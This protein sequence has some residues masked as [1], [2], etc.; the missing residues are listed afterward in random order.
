MPSCKRDA[1]LS[2]LGNTANLM[3]RED[4]EDVA[5]VGIDQAVTA[6]VA[7]GHLFSLLEAVA[8]AADSHRDCCR[9]RPGS[10]RRQ[11]AAPSG[12]PLHRV[13]AREGGGH[14]RVFF[15]CSMN[16][17]ADGVLQ[18]FATFCS[19]RHKAHKAQLEEGPGPSVQAWHMFLSASSPR[20]A[21]QHLSA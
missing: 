5:V 11:V 16:A 3:L 7:Q 15:Q 9:P 13:L 8:S 6:I 12:G 20:A 10:I 21:H 14:G 2:D 1:R 17:L 19:W 4:A 18:C